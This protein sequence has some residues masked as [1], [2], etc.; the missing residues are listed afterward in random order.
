M[1]RSFSAAAS[2]AS[3]SRLP[4]P[5]GSSSR[6]Y[7]RRLSGSPPATGD[8]HLPSGFA[9]GGVSPS[10]DGAPASQAARDATDTLGLTSVTH[11]H[12]LA[13]TGTLQ[14]VAPEGH[15]HSRRKRVSLARGSGHNDLVCSVSARLELN[16]GA[17]DLENPYLQSGRCRGS[18]TSLT[19]QLHGDRRTLVEVASEL[20]DLRVTEPAV[21]CTSEELDQSITHLSARHISTESGRS[22]ARSRPHNPARRRAY[23]SIRR[24]IRGLL[25]DRGS[26]RAQ[27]ARPRLLRIRRS[28]GQDAAC[29]RLRI[30]AG[31]SP[32]PR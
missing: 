15:A 22:G 2:R 26:P 27:A 18:W 7:H 28:G 10:E 12:R 19:N 17:P 16:L 32:S 25:A 24:P 31:S 29:F 6:T 14:G 11:R 4:S 21:V 8:R 20:L 13:S 9:N 23:S 3:P 1:R 5:H 30:L